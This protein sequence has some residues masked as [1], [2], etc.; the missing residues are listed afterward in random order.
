[1]LRVEIH[2]ADGSMVMRLYGRLTGEYAEQIRMLVTRCNPET[3]L[4]LDLTD[5]IFVDAA[6]EEALAAFGQQH[7]EFVAET[8]YA[9]NLCERLQLPIA[10]GRRRRRE[11]KG[12]QSVDT[13]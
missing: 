12:P 7:G 13:H 11:V 3:R 9:K 5:L 10:R 4:V 1:M 8:L 6:G 2:D